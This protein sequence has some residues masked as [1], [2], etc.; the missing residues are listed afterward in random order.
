[1]I[2]ETC[3]EQNALGLALARSRSRGILA[4]RSQPKRV[5]ERRGKNVAVSDMVRARAVTGQS[6][7]GGFPNLAAVTPADHFLVTGV[8]G[9]L[10]GTVVAELLTAP[11]SGRLLLMVRA[12]SP[13]EGLE[14]ARRSLERFEVPRALLAKLTVANI[15]C[16][17]LANVAAF[18]RDPRLDAVTHVVNC[19]GITSFGKDPD[20]WRVNVDGTLAFAHRLKRATGLKR[21]VH[22]STAMICGDKPPSV[23]EEDVSL[24][25]NG[26]HLVPYTESKAEAERRLLKEMAGVPFVIVRPTIIAGH[27]R[28]GCRPSGSIF[29]AF[30]MSHAL[31]MT[32]SP[33]DGK[34]DVVPVD[35]AA[36]AVLHLAAAKELR[37]NIYHVG[38]GPSYSSTFAEID[39]AFVKAD[40][41]ARSGVFHSGSIEEA[42]KLKDSFQQIFGQCNRRFMQVAIRLYG[43]FAALDATFD[44]SRLL[45]EGAPPPPK[46]SDY[47]G[48]CLDTCKDVGIYS[49]AMIDFV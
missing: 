26:Q 6:T 38:S 17:D 15:L 7:V 36:R 45:K 21:F 29:W 44:N 22:I 9:F 13:E 11:F 10:G 4:K 35:Y 2:S 49:Q 37:H 3:L 31:R 40:G 19:A 16:G 47:L 5:D 41:G 39:A 12:S 34:I 43:G 30:R 14:R 48:V 42:L 8:T 23:V 25:I 1:M 24:G 32:T 20:V 28:L 27:T 18:E 33:L 46:F